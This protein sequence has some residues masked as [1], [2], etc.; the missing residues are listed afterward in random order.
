MVS[1]GGGPIFSEAGDDPVH[2]AGQENGLAKA[3][4][5]A[6]PATKKCDDDCTGKD[7]VPHGRQQPA[8]GIGL[9][10]ASA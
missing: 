9:R 2:E 4:P 6:C 3:P 8:I 7:T 1:A 10:H 5:K